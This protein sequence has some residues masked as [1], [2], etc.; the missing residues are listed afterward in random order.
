MS[1]PKAVVRSFLETFS[2]GDIDGVLAG[3]IDD[4]S[5]WVSG[6]I[7]GM[8]GTSS[9]QQLGETLRQVKPLYTSGALEIR[10]TSMLAEG[11][12]VAVEAVS[13]ANLVN[14]R[15]YNNSYHFLFEVAATGSRR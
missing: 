4:A 8:S 9:K 5:W 12:Q 11:N 6:S 2:R 1:D 10:P 14:G 15:T 13:H 3:L 7:P